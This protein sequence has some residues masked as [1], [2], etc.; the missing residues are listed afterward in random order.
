MSTP[1]SLFERASLGQFLRFGLV[2]ASGVVVNQCVVV[3]L[4]VVGRD[5]FG[6]H[7]EAAVWQ[8]W[9]TAY[10]VRNYH[11]YAMGGFLVANLCNFMLNRHWTFRNGTRGPIWR[12][13]LPFLA[14]GLVGQGIGL[15]L[16]TAL[17][18]SGS[19]IAL[20]SD[21]FD[22]SSGLRNKLYWA[23]LIVIVV[24][25]PLNFVVNKLWTFRRAG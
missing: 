5:V 15:L 3:L 2:G 4:N 23:N 17:M 24:V 12:E 8:L 6:W 11:L 9:G 21:V 13:Y 1:P 16:L 18:H 19:P 22:G 25:T 10:N 14:V 20:P 7:Q